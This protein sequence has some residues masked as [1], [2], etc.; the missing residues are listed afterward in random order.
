MLYFIVCNGCGIFVVEIIA[1]FGDYQGMALFI[2]RHSLGQ[3]D[4]HFYTWSGV[5]INFCP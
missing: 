4:T 5:M 2:Y 3:I 1:T